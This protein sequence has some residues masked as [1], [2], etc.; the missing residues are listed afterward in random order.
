MSQ[1]IQ[2]LKN[3]IKRSESD[4]VKLQSEFKGLL[5]R[6]ERLENKDV[7]FGSEMSGDEIHEKLIEEASKL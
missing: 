4:I 5:K 7:I 3:R 6:M 1:E 2:A